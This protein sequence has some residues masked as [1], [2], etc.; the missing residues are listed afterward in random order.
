MSWSMWAMPSTNVR[1][2]LKA[3]KKKSGN[4]LALWV[5]GSWVP[6]R[7]ITALSEPELPL[8]ARKSTRCL[9]KPLKNAIAK[10]MPVDCKIGRAVPC[11]SRA[12]HAYYFN[13]GRRGS[14]RFPSAPGRTWLWGRRGPPPPGVEN[15]GAAWVGALLTL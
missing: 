1:F 12:P 10:M 6:A 5:P 8:K 15:L 2:D 13:K 3:P 14:A 9:A 4:N 7:C 11:G